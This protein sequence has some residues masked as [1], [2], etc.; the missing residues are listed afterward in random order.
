PSVL[1]SCTGVTLPAGATAFKYDTSHLF[2]QGQSMGGMYANMVSASDPR[3]KA[4]LPTG[5]GG[6]WSYFI[7]ITP[8]YPNVASLVGSLLLDTKATLTFMHP[9]LN[10]F[11]TAAEAIDPMGS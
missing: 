10:L 5:A 1:G 8:L 7:L 9:G 2:E 6:Y 3:I 4:T 11:E